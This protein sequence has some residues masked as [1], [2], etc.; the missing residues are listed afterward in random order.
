M[1][2]TQS[3]DQESSVTMDKPT[4]YPTTPK[5]TVIRKTTNN[6]QP[7]PFTGS[8]FNNQMAE[9]L[10]HQHVRKPNRPAGH[11][12]YF[13]VAAVTKQPASVKSIHTSSSSSSLK[14]SSTNKKSYPSTHNSSHVKLKKMSSTTS[15]GNNSQTSSTASTTIGVDTKDLKPPLPK[16]DANYIIREGRRY[17]KGHGSQ[18]F[19]LPCDDDENDRLMT[20]VYTISIII[21]IPIL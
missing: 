21:A 9:P 3:V 18:N 8:F 4:S 14:T 7:Q 19:I 17:W 6:R 16:E 2:N 1:G 5:A 11:V 15:S 10:P 20:M 12:N 13:E